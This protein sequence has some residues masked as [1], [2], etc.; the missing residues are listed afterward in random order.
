MGPVSRIAMALVL[1][2]A[3]G[4]AALAGPKNPDIA[5]AM[6]MLWRVQ[7]N[8]CPGIS[9]DP[10]ILAATTQPKRMTAEMLKGRF[11]QEFDKGF[12]MAGEAITGSDASAYC[13]S[14]V[15]DFFGGKKSIF[16]TPLPA[17]GKPAAGLKLP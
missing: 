10:A 17:P 11:R 14:W 4:A 6:G 1:L 16:G 3:T 15:T 8:I 9:F 7:D 2:A 13:Q 5:F 12:A